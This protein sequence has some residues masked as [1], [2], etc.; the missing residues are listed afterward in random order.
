MKIC[1][2]FPPDIQLTR[3]LFPAKKPNSCHHCGSSQRLLR[4]LKNKSKTACLCQRLKEGIY[5]NPITYQLICFSCNQVTA[6]EKSHLQVNFEMPYRV[7]GCTG[8]ANLGNTCFINVI[9]QILS[10]LV[11]VY[12]LFTNYVS[13]VSTSLAPSKSMILVSELCKV[14]QSL[15]Q[16]QS[17]ISPTEF[18]RCTDKEFSILNRH[19][20]QDSSEFFKLLYDHLEGSL[21]KHL[22]TDFLRDCF[23]WKIKTQITCKVCKSSKN[24]NEEFIELPLSIPNK[25]KIPELR[26]MSEQSLSSR[27]KVQILNVRKGIVN[28]FKL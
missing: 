12:K 15:W 25:S 27:D 4:D 13:P 23:M 18:I 7:L 17:T 3:D 2:H 11:C 16:G 28:K 24:S 8:L 1:E 10:N 14:L 19:D 5:F 21:S 20:H 9:L 22:K 6:L 26:Q